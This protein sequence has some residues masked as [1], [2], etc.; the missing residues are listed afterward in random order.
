[1]VKKTD[2]QDAGTARIRT[3]YVGGTPDQI[4][5]DR[6]YS[7]NL[8][9]VA[10]VTG[11][12]ITGLACVYEFPG[13][14][15]NAENTTGKGFGSVEFYYDDALIVTVWAAQ[16]TQINDVYP[17]G[18]IGNALFQGWMYEDAN[19][20]MQYTSRPVPL[21]GGMEGM[22]TVTVGTHDKVYAS[23]D[24]DAY[25]LVFYVDAG[26][27]AIYVDGDIVDS[28]GLVGQG[29][30]IQYPVAYVSAGTHTVTVKLSNGYTGVVEMNFNGETVTDGKINIDASTYAGQIFKVSITNIDVTQSAGSSDDGL[31]LTDYLLI[32]LVVLIVVMAIMVALRLMRS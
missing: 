8:G 27:D 11:A 2:T 25:T 9:S 28:K 22:T 14:T 3:L 24:Y 19:G 26:V 21:T 30:D 29:G 32:V 10:I 23:V 5:Y 20:V 31:G 17:A 12:G 7:A 6:T 15:V 16:N 1:M 13:S 18:Q 4:S